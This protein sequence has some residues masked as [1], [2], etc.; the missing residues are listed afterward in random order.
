MTSINNKRG[1]GCEKQGG[2]VLKGDV[3]SEGDQAGSQG[4]VVAASA[5]ETEP[6][7]GLDQGALDGHR[8][9]ELPRL[10]RAA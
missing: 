9:S 7:T 5:P 8:G 1:F 4:L 3:W 10:T 2:V 6:Q